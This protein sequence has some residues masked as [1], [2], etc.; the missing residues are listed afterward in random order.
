[1]IQH[2]ILPAFFFQIGNIKSVS[3]KMY[4]IFIIFDKI[5]KFIQK[6]RFI[7]F[8]FCKELDAAKLILTHVICQTDQ[9]EMGAS[10]RK[11]GCLDIKKYG[12]FKLEWQDIAVR[13][14][15]SKSRC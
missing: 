6:S 7:L 13:H 12:I 8:L 15:I 14:I 1:M 9:I 10:G 2:I 4:D 11:T 3:I 5:E